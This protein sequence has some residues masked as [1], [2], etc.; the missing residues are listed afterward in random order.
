MDVCLIGLKGGIGKTTTAIHIA[1]YLQKFGKTLLI[2]ADKNAS[3]IEWAKKGILD[4]EVCNLEGSVKHVRKAVHVVT[5]TKARPEEDEIKAAAEMYD[6]LILPSP[7]KTLDLD[8]LLKTRDLLSKYEAN[9]KALLTITPPP[10]RRPGGKEKLASTKEIEARELLAIEEVPMFKSTIYQ[11]TALEKSP[12]LGVTVDQYE[13]QYSANAWECYEKLG[14][15][16]YS[17]KE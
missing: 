3:A 1:S 6:L 11:Y 2:D 17:G 8:A 12:L 10:R 14:K 13:D 9:Y 15:E 16:I 4:F 5:D 7:P